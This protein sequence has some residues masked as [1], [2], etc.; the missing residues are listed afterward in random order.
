MN[1]DI[2][3]DVARFIEDQVRSGRYESAGA[4]VNAAVARLRDED[5]S[6]PEELDAEDIAAIEESLARMGRGDARPWEEVRA[7]LRAK[8]P[9]RRP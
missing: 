3:P 9:L 4:L 7:E 6:A 5:E 1:I 2:A 8:Y